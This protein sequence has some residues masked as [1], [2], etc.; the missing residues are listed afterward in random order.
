VAQG[1]G[2]TAP[3]KVTVRD[4]QGGED[5]VSFDVRVLRNP[6][7]GALLAQPTLARPNVYTLDMPR[8]ESAIQVAGELA[9]QARDFLGQI[10]MPEIVETTGR[11]VHFVRPEGGNEAIEVKQPVGQNARLLLWVERFVPL[12]GFAVRFNDHFDTQD[13]ESDKPGA[14]AG[15]SPD[16]VVTGPDGKPVRGTIV[17]DA[18][19]K[20]FS[21]MQ[22]SNALP[23]GAYQITLRSGVDGFHSFFGNLDGDRD[24]KPGGDYKQHFEI[25]KQNGA[26]APATATS[27]IAQTTTDEGQALPLYLTSKGDVSALSFA[28]KADARL[29][30]MQARLVEGLPHGASI[31]LRETDDGLLMVNITSPEPLPEGRI[32]MGHLYA[33]GAIDFAD[34]F[35]TAADSETFAGL[36]DD[37]RALD[38][39]DTRTSEALAIAQARTDAPNIDFSRAF[40]GFALAGAVAY[41]DSSLKSRPPK[42]TRPWQSDRVGKASDKVTVANQSLRIKLDR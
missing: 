7:A 30:I 34:G 26:Q 38:H 5:T 23:P 13:I 42:T 39:A 19:G 25:S 37:T 36:A 32:L 6:V 1:E 28:I 29:D 20:G 14:S 17:I 41:A 10:D 31:S 21:F 4:G 8:R 18:D 16:I 24:G 9:W 33:S 22:V 2:A 11:P 15:S 27:K 3:F 40:D 12:H 35:R